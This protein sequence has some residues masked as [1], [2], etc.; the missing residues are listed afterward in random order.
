MKLG[1]AGIAQGKTKIISSVLIN[2][3][4]CMK[5][6]DSN[7]AWNS[8]RFTPKARKSRVFTRVCW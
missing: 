2:Q 7:S 8:L 3:P 1:N 6:P 5:K 4:G